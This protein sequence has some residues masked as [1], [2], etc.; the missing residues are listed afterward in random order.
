MANRNCGTESLVKPEPVSS[1]NNPFSICLP[2]GGNL[3][4]DGTCLKYTEPETVPADGEYSG[5]VVKNGCIQGV[6]PPTSPLYTANTCAPVPNPC[7]CDDGGSSDITP[8]TLDGNMLT[9]DSLNRPLVQ[10]HYTAGDNISLSGNGTSASPL[11]V[12]C[13]VDSMKDII[14]GT[15]SILSVENRDDNIVISH[16]ESKATTRTINGMTFDAYGHLYSYTAPT[17]T[18][19]YIT[20]AQVLGSDSIDATIDNITNTVSLS[21]KDTPAKYGNYLLGGYNV[22]FSKKGV[23]EEIVQTITFP[24]G[25][26]DFDH[27]RVTFNAYGSAT[28]IAYIQS[29][30]VRHSV[31]KI[32]PAGTE[33]YRFDFSIWEDSGLRISIRAQ[34]MTSCV[35]T[36]D[37]N[38]Y[39]GTL[40][41]NI[42]Y[43]IVPS[44]TF[45]AGAHNMVITFG[46]T[47]P[48]DAILDVH[49]STVV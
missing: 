42:F 13:T 40:F 44:A 29:S 27:Y 19:Q 22:S 8:S 25:E 46:S 14:S 32:I 26:Y 15:P 7:D 3:S 18:S 2:F 41:G 11:V 45:A 12:S 35:V 28:A 38:I 23:L 24:S 39:A 5:V 1:C 21:L 34:N 36:I 30:A 49:L 4:M 16:V 48:T 9:L 43:D 33:E 10:L 6:V 31:S 47:I 37:G 20:T 17:I